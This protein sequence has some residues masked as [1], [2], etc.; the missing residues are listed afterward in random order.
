MMKHRH[1]S[2]LISQAKMVRQV[3]SQLNSETRHTIQVT[4]C[5]R[6]AQFYP[7]VA[8]R[9]LVREDISNEFLEA[10]RQPRRVAYHQRRHCEALQYLA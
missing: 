7:T 6:C 2:V 8:Q 4:S 5:E 10:N 3:S 9:Y 1:S